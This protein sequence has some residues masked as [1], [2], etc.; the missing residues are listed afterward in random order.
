[1]PRHLRGRR[2]GG[3][4]RP[5]RHPRRLREPRPGF[6]GTGGPGDGR[7]LLGHPA[8]LAQAV[9]LHARGQRR[10]PALAAALLSGRRRVGIAQQALGGGAVD[11]PRHGGRRQHRLR[12]TAERIGGCPEGRRRTAPPPGPALPGPPPPGRAPRG[13]PAASGARATRGSAAT[14]DASTAATVLSLRAASLPGINA[15]I[16]P[17]APR[18]SSTRSSTGGTPSSRASTSAYAAAARAPS[19]T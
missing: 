6:H 4:C 5:L 3:S 11:E 13:V 10:R 1:R 14:R 18:S 15:A 19:P 16:S 2:R 9:H 7:R 17:P 12:R 8:P